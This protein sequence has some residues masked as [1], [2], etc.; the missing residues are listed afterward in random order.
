MKVIVCR[1]SPTHRTPI[2]ASRMTSLEFSPYWN[3]P[4]G[5]LQREVLPR[6]RRD[7]GYLQREHMEIIDGTGRVWT[8]VEP[9]GLAALTGGQARVRQRPGPANA[10]GGVKFVFPN[11]ANVYFHDTPARELFAR[12]RRDFSHGCIRVEDPVKLA[13]FVLALQ[14]EW[15]SD[16]I[17]AAM[18]AGDT[19]FVALA[20]P[21]P[22]LIYYL[23]AMVD[24]ADGRLLFLSDP[25]GH[26]AT[27]TRALAARRASPAADVAGVQVHEVGGRVVAD[28]AG[29]QTDCGVAQ[30]G[31]RHPGKADVDRPSLE[32]QARFR[33][34]AAAALP[35]RLVGGR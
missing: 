23:T 9:E 14:P 25:Y 29:P 17:R 11:Q 28:A 32:V 31:Q 10:V 27:L 26:D 21:V 20:A 5:I 35:Q 1:D 2:F 30:V 3:V 33:H 12:T 16:R 34:A 24:P 7:P 19:Q 8:R 13:E 18:T 6:L 22:V 4:P 15:T